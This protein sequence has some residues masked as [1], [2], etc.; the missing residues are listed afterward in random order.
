MADDRSTFELAFDAVQ[1]P[2]SPY[3][4]AA[5]GR[6]RISKVLL[7]GDATDQ[8]RA[9]HI[10]EAVLSA[11]AT[12]SLDLQ[13]ALDAYGAALAADDLAM[14]FIE[15]VTDASGGGA[16][17]VRPNAANGF[18]NLLGASSAL[19]IPYGGFVCL[20]NFT[21]DKY[22]V[23]PTNKILDFVETGGALPVLLRI[24][25]WVRR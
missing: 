1:I 17:E 13:T 7:P 18:T 25:A 24:H 14:L 22:D 5:S 11:S 23:S 21:A 9:L 20:G 6:K 10:R 4:R 16:L 3:G 19:K 8:M 12:F 2:V 15:N